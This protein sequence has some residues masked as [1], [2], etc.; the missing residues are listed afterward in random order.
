M[1]G[2]L[3]ARSRRVGARGKDRAII[4]SHAQAM[5]RCEGPSS[6][7]NPNSYRAFSSDVDVEQ[8]GYDEAGGNDPKSDEGQREAIGRRR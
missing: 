8:R 2:P 4:F 1:V 5:R 7:I 3:A 6:A